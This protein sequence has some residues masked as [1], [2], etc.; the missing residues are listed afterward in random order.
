M[1]V[2]SIANYVTHPLDRYEQLIDYV[3]VR[4][5]TLFATEPVD[6]PQRLVELKQLRLVQVL[7]TE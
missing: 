5:G 3:Q 6:L 7:K 2:E 1:L 4:R